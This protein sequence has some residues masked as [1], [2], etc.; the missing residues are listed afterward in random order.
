MAG[1]PAPSG[2]ADVLVLGSG[3]AGLVAALRCAHA[4]LGVTVLESRAVLGGTTAMSGAALWVP[5]NDLARRAGMQDSPEDALRYLAAVAPP[6]WEAAEHSLWKA[7]ARAAPEMLRFLSETTPL[8]FT[9]C[10]D[11]DPYP[12]A[13]GGKVGARIVSVGALG[14]RGRPVQQ[15]PHIPHLFTYP[16]MRRLDPW[17]H[18]LRAALRAAPQLLRRLVLGERAQGTALVA[19]LVAGCSAAGVTFR[20]RCSARALIQGPDGRITGVRT[21]S[22]VIAARHAVVIATGGFERDSARMARHFAGPFGCIAS[23]PGNLGE[24]QTMAE[25]VGAQ[26]ARMDQANIAPALPAQLDGAPLPIGTFHHHE[27][28]AFLVNRAGRR[29]VNE[30]TFNLGEVLSERDGSGAARHL[31]AWMILD[32]ATRRASPLLRHYLRR[33]PKG[34]LHSAP[35]PEAL[36]CALDLPPETFSATLARFNTDARA[37]RDRQFERHLDPLTGEA[38]GVSR[39]MPLTRAPYLAL[40]FNLTLLGTKG[41]PRTDAAGRVQNHKGRAIPGL[42]AC[43]LAMANPIGTRAAGSGTTLGPNLTW[44]YICAQSILS[45]TRFTPAPGL[46]PTTTTPASPI[47][48][49]ASS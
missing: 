5:G 9:L 12:M 33:A 20:T 40:P 21:D 34:Y 15:R 2:S 42:Y 37:G 43:G 17:H 11:S 29:F 18:P 22:G 4:G 13:P 45:E 35:S 26:L 10:D 47:P 28:G 8:S 39:M 38:D 32:T 48:Q 24:G 23:S 19:G 49:G 16:E 41:G 27:P 31:P 3:G 14:L 36:A 46:T 7:F 1:L 25:A 6:G 30:Y 44:G